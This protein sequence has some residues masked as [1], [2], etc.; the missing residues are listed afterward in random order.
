M[1]D[2]RHDRHAGGECEG[3][4]QNQENLLHNRLPFPDVTMTE[5]AT[6]LCDRRHASVLF[7]G[8]AGARFRGW[9]L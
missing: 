5:P 1:R 9:A 4:S 2:N 3:E 6:G 7:Q 8:F